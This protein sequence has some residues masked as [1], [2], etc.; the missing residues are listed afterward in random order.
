MSE[1]PR[2][3]KRLRRRSDGVHRMR[4]LDERK[5][6]PEISVVIAIKRLSVARGHE[7]KRAAMRVPTAGKFS[8]KVRG[9]ALE[10]FHHRERIRKNGMIEPLQNELLRHAAGRKCNAESVVD[11]AAAEGFRA[12]KFAGNLERLR[13]G[14]NIVRRIWAGG[15]NGISVAVTAAAAT[16]VSAAAG[17]F[18]RGSVVP[19]TGGSEGGKLLVQLGGAAVRAFRPAPVGGAHEDFAVAP[20]FAAMKFVDWHGVKVI[21]AAENSSRRISPFLSA[22]SN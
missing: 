6:A 8:R 10:I 19:G 16:V 13:D 14:A 11:M 12:Q 7:R 4:S 9:D 1:R 2:R 20:A 5:N 3:R 18:A 15:H 21:G 22:G 17:F